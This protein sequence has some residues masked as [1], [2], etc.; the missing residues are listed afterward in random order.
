[1]AKKIYYINAKFQTYIELTNDYAASEKQ[2]VIEA[3]NYVP[4]CQF[5]FGIG[6]NFLPLK[7]VACVGQVSSKEVGKL[8]EVSF[9]GW[10]R[11]DPKNWKNK[12]EEQ[13]ERLI[14]GESKLVFNNITAG[15]F[16]F[17][18]TNA[19]GKEVD[20]LPTEFDVTTTKP[21]GIEFD[22]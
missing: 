3:I 12:V 17:N 22:N 2:E 1:M 7:G 13:M 4:Q 11:I 18:A 9:E 21:D 15:S 8:N 5:E 14:K 20:N 16:Q 10:F 19:K 6:E